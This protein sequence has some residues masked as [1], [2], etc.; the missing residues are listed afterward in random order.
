MSLVEALR[1]ENRWSVP[2]VN[3]MHSHR[4]LSK[5]DSFP[6]S[7][8][9]P[10]DPTN[11]KRSETEPVIAND[12]SQAKLANMINDFKQ[13]NKNKH[14]PKMLDDYLL[15]LRNLNKTKRFQKFFDPLR[16]KMQLIAPSQE[17]LE[18]KVKVA[19]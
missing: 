2:E 19:D 7:L 6:T 18:A 11:L 4:R 13:V 5:P 3:I 8:F 9:N 14:V 16:S 12:I 15:V 17:I 10:T 1:K